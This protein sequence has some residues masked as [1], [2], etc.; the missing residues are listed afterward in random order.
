[1]EI[2]ENVFNIIE[3]KFSSELIYSKK[4][5]KAEEKVNINRGFQCLYTTIILIDSIHRKDKNYY[6]K[7]FLE[8]YYF[9]E[10]IKFIAVI[11]RK[12]I[13]MKNV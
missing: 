10:D 11:L 13:M 6:P 2:L 12:N 4:N 3:N 9:I 8:K 5:K 1:M 7:V